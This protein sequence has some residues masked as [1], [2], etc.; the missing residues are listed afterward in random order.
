VFETCA[1]KWSSTTRTLIVLPFDMTPYSLD[2]RNL[3]EIG[4]SE[5][6]LIHRI[7]GG[8]DFSYRPVFLGIETRRFGNWICFRPR[9]KETRRNL[10]SWAPLQRANLNH[11]S[12]SVCC[13]PSSER[14]K[15]YLSFV[16]KN[17]PLYDY[18][19]VRVPWSIF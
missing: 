4:S 14:F 15:I 6:V 11:P 10:L 13:T 19:A 18:D 2:D 16:S 7:S 3:L 9:V 1:A 5:Q 8:F 12:N 17:D